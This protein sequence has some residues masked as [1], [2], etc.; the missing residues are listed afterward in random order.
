MFE[1]FGPTPV[2]VVGLVAVF[3]VFILLEFLFGGKLL[4]IFSDGKDFL[5]S[6]GDELLG[7]G[8][9]G[10]DIG[11]W[12]AAINNFV[13]MKEKVSTFWA[14][15]TTWEITG[16]LP[17]NFIP[18]IGESMEIF[19]IVPTSTIVIF[20]FN[21]QKA[22]G[23]AL[24]FLDENLRIAEHNKIGKWRHWRDKHEEIKKMNSA[25][26]WVSTLREASKINKELTIAV[27]D[28]VANRGKGNIANLEIDVPDNMSAEEQ[29]KLK[30]DLEPMQLQLMNVTESVK[31]SK[32][33]VQK[34][35]FD[36]KIYEKAMESVKGA[37]NNLR[38]A[39]EGSLDQLEADEEDIEKKHEQQSEAAQQKAAELKKD[40]DSAKRK[41]WA[42]IKSNIKDKISDIF[43]RKG[44]G[45]FN[46]GFEG[47]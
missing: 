37:V 4:A 24:N 16:F 30:E 2:L 38:A 14:F 31:K 1:A 13:I 36:R 26:K 6:F 25:G 39:T 10:L 44:Q 8:V 35:E 45:G 22:A 3:G 33:L 47:A 27:I 21:K 7:I 20:L 17:L 19:N 40:E 23:D 12:L 29:E 32:A 9:A 41:A 34:S 15:F 46:Q 5:L 28:Y 18:G 42:E 11:D 43:R